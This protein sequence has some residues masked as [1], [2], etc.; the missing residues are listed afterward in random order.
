MSGGRA[1]VVNGASALGTLAVEAL[2]GAGWSVLAVSPRAASGWPDAVTQLAADPRTD[3]GWTAIVDAAGSIDALIVAPPA[4]GPADDPYPA[5]ATAWLGAKHALP[6]FRAAGS[7]TLL[8]LGFAAPDGGAEPAQDAACESIRLLTAAALH[9]ARVSG[10][11][12]RSN[13]LFCAADADP[14][15]VR[16]NILFLADARSR[17][18]SGAE[19]TL[20]AGG[21]DRPASADL[22]GK[23]VLVTGA[24][25]G[26]GRATAI[27]I[28]RR[29]GWV[30]VGGRKLD[31]AEETL[32]LVRE[33][34]GDGCVIALD[35][36]EAEAWAAAAAHLSETRGALHGLVNN[37]GEARNRPI[38]Q[39]EE[40]DLAFLAGINIH[41]VRLGMDAMAGLLATGR[42]VVLNI[43]SVAGIKAG[44]GG[45]AY[46]ATKAAMIGLSR[47]YAAAYAQNGTPI[48]VNSVQ[49]GLI[50]SDSVADSL[51]EEGAL[52]FRAMIEPKTPLGRVGVP[53]EVAEAVAFLLSDAAAPISGQAISVSGGLE[54]GW[55]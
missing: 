4:D 50:W 46:S 23:T 53:E 43:S 7:G 40:S 12:L 36:T 2:A 25:S 39:L 24:T 29:G 41:G 3:A 31:L 33:A 49:P 13:R 20:A 54:L 52:A 8:T 34:G 26:I 37:A 17:F 1:L 38:E 27:E 11:S 30:A 19:I 42:G 32:A 21:H 28:G 45:S 44:P 47:G 18:L 51:G 9:D 14:G 10:I 48:R 16:E 15:A 5:I 55:P 6:L 35:V 22:A